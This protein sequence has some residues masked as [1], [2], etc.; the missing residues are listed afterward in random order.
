MTGSPD[1][2]GPRFAMLRHAC[3]CHMHVFGGTRPVCAPGGMELHAP[4]GDARRLAGG[5]DGFVGPFAMGWLKDAT[6]SF[7][8]GLIGLACLGGLSAVLTLSLRFLVR[9]E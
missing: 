3:D 4:G 1:D 2:A 8:T 6:S 7:T 5:G 9:E